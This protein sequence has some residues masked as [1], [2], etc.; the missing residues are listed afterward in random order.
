VPRFRHVL[1]AVLGLGLLFLGLEFTKQGAMPLRSL[2]SVRDFLAFAA[3]SYVLAFLVGVVLTVVAQS[4]ATVSIVAITL[5]NVGLLT[6]DQTIIIVLGASLGSGLSIALLSANLS[7]VGRQI[8][9]LQV[10]VKSI[11][12]VVLLPVFAVEVAGHL[13]GLKAFV[14]TLAPHAA[15]QVALVYL[16]LQVVSAVLSTALLKPIT[17]AIARFSP[18]TDEERLSQPHFLYAEALED[19]SS[20]LDLVEREQVRAFGYLPGLLDEVRS[21]GV[22]SVSGGVLLVAGNSLVEHCDRFLA[23][24]VDQTSARDGLDDIFNLQKRNELLSELF[25][26][27]SGY[28]QAVG[29]V[30]TRAEDD[31]FA[32]LLFAL[33]ESLHTI[34]ELASDA[35][36]SRDRSDLDLVLE[37]SSDR[38]VQMDGIRR[39]IMGVG[40]M[41][42]L[43]HSTLY[44]STTLFERCLW[45]THRYAELVDQFGERPSAE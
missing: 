24:I 43:D 32:R 8:A 25:K 17:A 19:A 12:V 6:L 40:E 5:T 36:E 11:G 38:S 30:G 9:W 20:A 45:L 42:A 23:E 14:A 10:A 41:T 1:G 37:F 31:G 22:S 15:G 34:L 21:D 27:V 29:Q 18:P 2:E 39:R 44:T 28:T 16:S 26:A 33:G 35:F 7:G 3:S 4:S 13:P